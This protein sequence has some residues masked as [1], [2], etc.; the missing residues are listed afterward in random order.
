MPYTCIKVRLVKLDKGLE[1][2]TISKDTAVE[3]ILANGGKFF[4]VTFTK[5]NGDS[6]NMTA[7]RG[8]TRYVTGEGLKYAPSDY[9]LITV[10][11][12]N[13]KGYR[14]VNGSTITALRING[15]TYKVD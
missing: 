1:K 13:A 10:Y 7:R 11:D 14:M 5:K 3:K 2:M 12:V 6:R 9:G 4:G 15:E 8:V